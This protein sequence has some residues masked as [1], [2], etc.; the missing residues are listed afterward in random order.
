MVMPFY[1]HGKEHGEARYF[2]NFAQH[3][4]FLFEFPTEVCAPR[5]PELCAFSEKAIMLAKAARFGD[6]ETFEA[7]REAKT[8]MQA[9]KLGRQVRGFDEQSWAEVVETVAFEVV[10]QKF[11]QVPGLKEIL[12]RTGS[13]IIAEASPRDTIWGIGLAGTDPRTQD[14]DQW[15]GRNILGTALMRA[16]HELGG[17]EPPAKRPKK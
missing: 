13:Q 12:L 2:S 1:G 4:P 11:R 17:E 8:P 3:E 10:L 9:K 15:K 5:K 7:I 16:R 14:P 6:A